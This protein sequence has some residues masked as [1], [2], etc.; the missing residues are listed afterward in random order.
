M[1]VV[2]HHGLAGWSNIRATARH[3]EQLSIYPAPIGVYF[4]VLTDTDL[5]NKS[6]IVML[7]FVLGGTFANFDCVRFFYRDGGNKKW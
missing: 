4:A 5:S 7:R 1:L 6:R 3:F 2:C